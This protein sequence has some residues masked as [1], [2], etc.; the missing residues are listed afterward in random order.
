MRLPHLLLSVALSGTLIACIS[1]PVTHRFKGSV[2]NMSAKEE[3]ELGRRLAPDV[4]NQFA[5]V[6][7]DAHAS[8]VLGDLVRSMV[9]LSPRRDELE[10]EFQIL[11]SS[12]PNAMALPG[13]HVY[14]TRGMLE[15][16]HS[17]AEFIGI[18][19]HE[20]GHVDH[21]HAS[22]VPWSSTVLAV[23]VIPFRVVHKWLPIGRRITG[24]ASS[25]VGAPS[26]LV[27]L[28]FS[29]KQELEADQRGL[30]F[31]AQ[32]GYDP[33]EFEQVFNVFERLEKAEGGGSQL[34]ILRTHPRNPDRI[35]AIE[36]ALKTDYPALEGQTFR[37]TSPEVADVLAR[38][39][40]RAPAFE[41]YDQAGS[42]LG[43]KSNDE[44]RS[45]AIDLVSDA[46][47]LV[48]DE[49]LFW[50][51]RG[52][53]AIESNDTPTALDAFQRAY[54]SYEQGSGSQGHWKPAFYLGMI[55]L[56][57]HDLSR[58]MAMLEESLTCNASN[59]ATHFLIGVTHEQIGE[60]WRALEAYRRAIKLAPDGSE[61]S[62]AAKERVGELK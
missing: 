28:M 8:Q 17:E 58:A 50:I 2:L 31:A 37:K 13:G 52:E 21:R 53:L 18:M 3:R 4:V 9:D 15:Q 51:M 56:N 34:T 6:A 57:S 32:L 20:F 46:L 25:V 11:N 43:S 55:A 62:D 12:I 44:N 33:R 29:R 22:R 5:G 41:L 1:D 49:P 61:V 10:F 48:P 42:L 36:K 47:E 38:F 30:Y 35:D 14:I 54:N 40:D 19:G 7:P 45:Q 16:L 59:A 27:G 24:A 26:K 39:R 23:P 60:R